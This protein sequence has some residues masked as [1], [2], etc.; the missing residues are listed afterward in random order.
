MD[1][2]KRFRDTSKGRVTRLYD[3]LAS[4]LRQLSPERREAFA[5]YVDAETSSTQDLGRPTEEGYPGQQENRERNC[6]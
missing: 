1:I 2:H 3:D 4:I 5:E 6:N